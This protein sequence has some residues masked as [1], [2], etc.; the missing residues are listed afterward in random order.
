MDVNIL[1]SIVTVVSLVAFIGIVVWT[2]S[3]RNRAG[4]DEAA[5]LP[6][7]ETPGSAGASKGEGQ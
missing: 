6:F 1:R 4:F 3:R 5:L 7:N 2:F